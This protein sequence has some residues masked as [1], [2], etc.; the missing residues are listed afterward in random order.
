[1]GN[2]QIFTS[3]EKNTTAIHFFSSKHGNEYLK[4]SLLTNYLKFT[5]NL[6]SHLFKNL[7]KY[8]LIR[9]IAVLKF[10]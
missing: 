4:A 9:S 2:S 7:Y 3:K 1:M 10:G 8:K 6:S 5:C